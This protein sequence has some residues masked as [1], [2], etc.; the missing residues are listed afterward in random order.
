MVR[1]YIYWLHVSTR[2]FDA[3]FRAIPG[4]SVYRHVLRASTSARRTGLLRCRT[5]CTNGRPVVARDTATFRIPLLIS[6]SLVQNT[7]Q[8]S[9]AKKEPRLVAWWWFIF[10]TTPWSTIINQVGHDCAGQR[11]GLASEKFAAPLCSS[12]RHLLERGVVGFVGPIYGSVAS[13]C[14]PTTDF[15]SRRMI[16]R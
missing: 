10:W 9:S 14:C 1:I 6:M 16:L 2:R 12:E 15:P 11:L 3:C 4:S 13:S 5:M 7:N 8:N